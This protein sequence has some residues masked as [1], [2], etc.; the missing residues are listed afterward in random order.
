MAAQFVS[1][2]SSVCFEASFGKPTTEKKQPSFLRLAI[3]SKTNKTAD[4]AECHTPIR[5]NGSS[6]KSC[7]FVI[8]QIEKS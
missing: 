2:P 7:D 6:D 5:L 4:A 1:S 8:M 3:A